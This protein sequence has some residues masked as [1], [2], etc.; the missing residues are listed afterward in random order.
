MSDTDKNL[1]FKYFS[2]ISEPRSS[3]KR[4][5]LIDIITISICAVICGEVV[6][7]VYDYE[8][9]E[10]DNEEYAHAAYPIIVFNSICLPLS[11]I[12]IDILTDVIFDDT[13]SELS[14]WFWR[15]TICVRCARSEK[16]QTVESH[17]LKLKKMMTERE[18]EIMIGLKKYCQKYKD[19][20]IFPFWCEFDPAEIYSWWYDTLQ[21]MIHSSKNCEISKWIGVM[22]SSSPIRSR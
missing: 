13:E 1:I 22:N 16:S 11:A 6:P 14:E 8:I 18:A 5:K 2:E 12:F 7:M 19:E 17:A 15:F 21:I 4:H 20:K 9:F 10:C 3:N